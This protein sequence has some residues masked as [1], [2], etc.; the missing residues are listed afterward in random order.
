MNQSDLVIPIASVLL[1]I[2]ALILLLAQ[3][4]RISLIALALQYISVFLLVLSVWPLA[5]AA[6]KLIAGWISAAVLGM[7]ISSNSELRTQLSASKDPAND[8]NGKNPPRQNASGL[9]ISFR[10]LTAGLV[11][12]AIASQLEL[13]TQWLPKLTSV[14]A[15][16][17]LILI[18]FGLIKLGFTFQPFPILLA[19]LT[20]LAGFEILYAVLETSVIS[21]GLFAAVNLGLAF[22]GAYLLTA[23]YMETEA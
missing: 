18:G 22:N 14:Y 20:A 23:P 15:W 3:D 1:T 4:W 10:V 12:L 17:G 5:M 21:A 19:L 7:A 11:A 13:V 2:T 8:H 6:A 9:G 16:A